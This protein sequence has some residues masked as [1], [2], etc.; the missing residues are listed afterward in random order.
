LDVSRL[1][2]AGATEVREPLVRVRPRVT[3]SSGKEWDLMAKL[4]REVKG[5]AK[6]AAK[7]KRTSGKKKG[8]GASRGAAK[9]EKSARRL[10]K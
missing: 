1:A 7:G 10:L 6:K 2:N 9:A 8:P 3:N 4:E 5:A